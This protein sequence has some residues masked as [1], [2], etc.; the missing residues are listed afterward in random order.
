[1][2]INGYKIIYI[3]TVKNIT[4]VHAYVNTG[5]M[6]E[7]EKDSGIAH[8]LEHI[9]ADSWHKCKGNCVNFWAKKGIISNAQTNTVYTRYFIVG[10]TKEMENMIDYMASIITKPQF[11]L[12][13]IE[14]SKHA[15]KDEL[16]IRTNSPEWKLYDTFYK[17]IKDNTVYNGF[18]RLSD[19]PL[20]IKNLET[21]TKKDIINFY[22]KWYRQNNIFF[23]IVSNKSLTTI[24]SYFSKYLHKRPSPLVSKPINT[25]INW[26]NN[27]FT[28]HRK[29]AEK[30]SFIIGF[31]NNKQH[32]QDYL[33][34]NLIQDML[35]GDISS[36]L[37]RILRDKLG[38]IYG[39][40]LYF[41]TDKSYILS[42]FEVTCQFNNEKLLITTLVN[43][44][45]DF[46]SGK[47]D[48]HLLKRSKERLSI[49]DMNNSRDNTEFLNLFYA[50]QFIMSGKFD[51]TPDKYMKIVNNTSKQKL[52][53][54]VKRMFQFDKMIIACETK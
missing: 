19:Y 45:R 42:T 3:P 12:K 39:I 50:N 22:E 7:T 15:V 25:S 8:L 32:P 46:V 27:T 47:F 35:T 4:S 29:D 6:Y 48:S 13:C 54:V 1:M 23:V 36:L 21:I 30:S 20:K 11:D 52:T 40:K 17:S 43:T 5:N 14:R 31:I 28:L 9:I 26:I 44:L 49:M 10:L 41:D 51:I 24:T 18:S 16:L 53:E 37:Y 34:Y 33:Y 2:N 38:L